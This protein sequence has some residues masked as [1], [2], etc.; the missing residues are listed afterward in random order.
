MLRGAF[1]VLAVLSLLLCAAALAAWGWG[2]HRSGGR[3]GVFPAAPPRDGYFLRLDP[4]RLAL[5]RTPPP[6]PQDAQARRVLPALFEDT[7]VVF[8]FRRWPEG[9]EPV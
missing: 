5:L 6:G 1:N 7:K 2:T 9:S 4:D 3:P 8:G